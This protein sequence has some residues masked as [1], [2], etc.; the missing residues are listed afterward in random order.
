MEKHYK[1]GGNQEQY[2]LHF[3]ILLIR[4]NLNEKE[5]NDVLY[6]MEYDNINLYL[7]GDMKNLILLW[8]L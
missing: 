7:T 8:M 4:S 2:Y 5:Y 1:M 3:D 6:D